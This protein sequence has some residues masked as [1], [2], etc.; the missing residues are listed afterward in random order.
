MKKEDLNSFVEQTHDFIKGLNSEMSWKER[1]RV[2]SGV[3]AKLNR[4]NKSTM[5]TSNETT[6]KKTPVKRASTS[7]KFKKT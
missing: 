4:E 3:Y 7:K 1:R 6:P 5:A 2:C